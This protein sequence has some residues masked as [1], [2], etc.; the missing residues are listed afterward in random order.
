MNQALRKTVESGIPLIVAV[1]MASTT[2]ADILSLPNKGRILPQ[3]D[4]DLVLIDADYNVKWTMIAGSIRPASYIIKEWVG[5][6][7][8]RVCFAYNLEYQI[9]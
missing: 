7:I 4:A 6:F 2:P 1:Q 5:N 9:S 3:K 8:R